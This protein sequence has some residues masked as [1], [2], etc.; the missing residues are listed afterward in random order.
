M[1]SKENLYES[2]TDIL[3]ITSND[4][5]FLGGD[6]ESLAFL[7]FNNIIYSLAL[8]ALVF[9][10]FYFCTSFYQ[11]KYFTLGKKGKEYNNEWRGLQHSIACY[12]IL[13]TLL[14]LQFP[15]IF[16]YLGLISDDGLS[17]V[18]FGI[19]FILFFVLKIFLDFTHIN[20]ISDLLKE[21]KYLSFYE[22]I[23]VFFT[24]IK[25]MITPKPKP[26]EKPSG[27]KPLAK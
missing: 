14:S 17:Q 21:Y 10:V 15:L 11:F 24:T 5:N 18:F 20:K 1:P 22:Q 13:W 4:R 12:R 25:T 16:F 9:S 6:L 26:P 2:P 8:F 7:N 3:P 23:S 27:K 19:F